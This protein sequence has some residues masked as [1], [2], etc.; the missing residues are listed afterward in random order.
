MSEH[1]CRGRISGESFKE[2]VKRVWELI[3]RLV[4][5]SKAKKA[6]YLWEISNM[7]TYVAS[8]LHTEPF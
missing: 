3:Q 7:M 8:W 4:C 5:D 2:V 6:A 1:V